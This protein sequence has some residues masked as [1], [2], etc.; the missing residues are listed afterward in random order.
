MS[1]KQ[2]I[3][4]KR[5]TAYMPS[6]E[7]L[8]DKINNYEN[9]SFDIFDTLLKRN[10][11]EP[12]DVFDIVQRY[13]GKEYPNFKVKRID[14]WKIVLNR[15]NEKVVGRSWARRSAEKYRRIKKA[16]G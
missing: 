9:V 3:N 10:V 16:S 14:A 15:P 4:K 11:K 13:V 5:N 8:I 6:Y 12:T 1:L 7:N 2:Y